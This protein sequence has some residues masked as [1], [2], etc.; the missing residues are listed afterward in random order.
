MTQFL[1]DFQIQELVEMLKLFVEAND[2]MYVKG[3]SNYHELYSILSDKLKTND[4]NIINDIIYQL[5]TT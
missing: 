1:Q 4:E 3:E 2:I 5:L